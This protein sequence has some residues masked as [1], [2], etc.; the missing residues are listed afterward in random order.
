MAP[1]PDDKA[2]KDEGL[3]LESSDNNT[4]ETTLALV[5]LIF[6][7]IAFIAA[8]LQALLQYLTS[9]QRDKCLLGAIGAWNVYTKTRWDLRNWRIVVQYPKLQLDPGTILA[10][11]ARQSMLLREW[12]D[13]KITNKKTAMC[14]LKSARNT[15]TDKAFWFLEN[16]GTV[17]TSGGQALTF[18]D[19]TITQKISWIWFSI[20]KRRSGEMPFARAGWCN[21]L[22]MLDVVPHEIMI[23]HY[24]NA[25]I[26]PSS[27]DVPIQRMKLEDLCL[28]CYLA[29][30]KDV[31]INLVD[32]TIN[33]QN[34]Y[35][36]LNTQEIP[37]L[38]KFVTV[39]GDFEGLKKII[40]IANTTQLLEVM[41]MAKGAI[42][43]NEFF[44]SLDY[45]DEGAILFGLARKWDQ[46]DWVGHREDWLAS[47]NR[48]AP[49]SGERAKLL[50]N[51]SIKRQAQRFSEYIGQTPGAEWMD[52][53]SS[54][55]GSCN[56][57]IIKYLAI[58]PFAGI[59][60]AVPQKLFFTPY[61]PHLEQQR[62]KWFA[63]RLAS[64]NGGSQ[65]ILYIKESGVIES[66]LISGEIPF[67]RKKSD[68]CITNNELEVLPE[69][70][71]WAWLPNRPVIRKWESDVADQAL[72]VE[73]CDLCIPE[74]VI[75]LI[76]GSIPSVEKASDYIKVS[77]GTS[78]QIYTT[79]SAILLSLL[80]VDVR[81]QAIWSI[82][83]EDGGRFSTLQSKFDRLEDP[84][85]WEQKEAVRNAMGIDALT[86][87]FIALWFE[88]GNRVDLTGDPD[89]LVQKL[90]L[91]L[92]DWESDDTPCIP[93]LESAKKFTE[94]GLD[95][96]I[97]PLKE[98]TA[99]LLDPVTNGIG[100]TTESTPIGAGSQATDLDM[101]SDT[102]GESSPPT[103]LGD[104]SELFELFSKNITSEG[105]RYRKM[106][107]LKSRKELVQWVQGNGKNGRSSVTQILLMP[108]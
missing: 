37:G 21:L 51:I 84:P 87:D 63:T 13:T 35:I 41:L 14:L 47:I 78:Q 96:I 66:A 93:E 46:K 44:P 11:R 54:L 106:K 72:D 32:S 94:G 50:N 103:A 8:F 2:L 71:S 23:S 33:G 62:M 28:L 36:K 92:D 90:S 15:K 27:I 48:L 102:E 4:T 61:R 34:K 101:N 81:L 31:E 82:L 68:F 1:I 59:W 107:E 19:L 52:A 25:D 88:L 17:L 49:D 95:G 105:G 39:D 29:N 104:L 60:T 42:L 56:P 85:T 69:K 30:I 40:A 74:V 76:D 73:N 86:C 55:A 53:W 75:R 38:G 65:S 43:G 64:K 70:Y 79:E 100:K 97:G 3:N 22:T 89:Y 18:W 6:A 67:L 57:T 16:H 108:T 58:M 26:I 45:F 12:S 7:A 91:I 80:L 77:S 83:E 99:L 9:N 98:A 20:R 24:E 10:V 5:A